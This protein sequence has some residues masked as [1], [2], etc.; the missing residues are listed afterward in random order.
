MLRV[1]APSALLGVCA[2]PCAR[3]DL[4]KKKWVTVRW[5]TWPKPPA[6]MPRNDLCQLRVMRM[7]VCMHGSGGQILR[8]QLALVEVLG[9]PLRCCFMVFSCS[10]CPQQFTC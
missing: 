3:R 9:L 6:S 5:P 2:L 7:Q 1:R 8:M 10:W 4:A